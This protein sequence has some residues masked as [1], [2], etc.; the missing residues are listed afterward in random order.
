MKS[1]FFLL[2]A[3][4]P[5][6][7]LN[8]YVNFDTLSAVAFLLVILFLI[9]KYRKKLDFQPMLR[10]GKVPLVYAVLWKTK[11]GISFMDRIGSKYRE[12]VKLI[13][14]CFI[15]FGFFGMILISLNILYLLLKLF[16]TPRETAEGVSLVLP[17]TNIPGLGYLSFWHFLI[18]LFITILIHEFA[19]GIV[20]R[21]HNVPVNSSGLGVFSLVLPIFPLAFVEPDEKKLQKDKDI[22]QYSIFAAG[23][24]INIFFAL[25]ILLF[26]NLVLAPVDNAVTHPVG[27]SFTGLMENYSAAEAGMKP[28]MIINSVNG[29]EVLDYTAFS[30]GVGT[31]NSGDQ[32]LLGSANGT[33]LITAKPA[34]DNPDNAYI[35]ILGVQN[36][37]RIN[38]RF[39]PFDGTYFWFRGLIRW[40]FLINLAIGLMNLLPLMVTDGGRML[41]TALDKVIGDS[42]KANKLWT[43]VGMVFIFTLLLALA[44]NYG[45]KLVSVIGFS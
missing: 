37:R 12:L 24:M 38:A 18:T 31:L 10:I 27:I 14:Y 13:G 29:T 33:F 11:F 39:E 1:L 41:K 43:F 19:H 9:L 25:I 6:F 4:T 16:I 15:G 7:F 42:E 8:K 26:M 23:P 3:I 32:I 44:I 45:G 21:A 30:K 17:L 35:G 34:K 2:F 22:V 5:L 20:A 40:L 28:G 36:E